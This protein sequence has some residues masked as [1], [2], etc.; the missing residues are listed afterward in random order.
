MR[1]GYLIDLH[2]GGYDQPMPTPQD[3]HETMEQMI[4]EGIIA[5]K[6]G[7]HSIQIPD[8]HGR[9][10][11]YFP[12]PEQILTILARETDRIAIGTF[13]LVHTLMHPMKTAE[14]FAVIDNLSKG[15]LYMHACRGAITP[16]TGSSSGSRRS[17]CSG[18]SRRRS[19][20]GSSP[21][22]VSASTS[23]ASTGR[24]SRGC[25]R[26]A[27]PA[28]RLADLGWRQRRAG[29]DPALGGLRRLLD[30]A[31]RS[32]C[33]R[34]SGRSR[35][36][37]TGSARTELGKKPYIV[38]MRDG[39][40]ADSFEHAAAQFGTHFV[41]EMRF[42][43]RQGIFTHH[44]DF[45]RES[46][47][48]SERAAPHLIMGTPQQCI[49]QLERYHEEFGV[50]YFTIRFRMPT[51]PSMEAARE[52][53]QRFGEEVVQPI[54]KKYPAPDHPAIPAACRW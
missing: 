20:S 11:C 40:V 9:T 42:Y 8:R 5:E 46:D 31:I 15:R 28:G 45:Q 16:G 48:T 38:M 24:S 17:T 53:I 49:E 52:Q 25:S 36:G 34:R 18:A 13:T 41:E 1:I 27:L 30:D 44:P 7:F 29:R 35:P 37:S 2:K 51:G 26:R 33:A 23:T 39:W 12:G 3:A 10:E 19:R 14:E 22:R 43:Y 4:E 47:I 54:H 21:S 50:D 32:R 6:A